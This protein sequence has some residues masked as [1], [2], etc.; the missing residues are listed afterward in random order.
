MKAL[1]DL[2]VAVA[3]ILFLGGIAVAGI[4]FMWWF[5]RGLLR[6]ATPAEP[7]EEVGAPVPVRH[8]PRASSGAVALEEP[9][10]DIDTDAYSRR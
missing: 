3:T 6:P 5:V 1:L 7:G 8:G 10:E 2:V 9:D 4:G